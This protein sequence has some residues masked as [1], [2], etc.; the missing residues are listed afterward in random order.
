MRTFSLFTLLVLGTAPLYTFAEGTYAP[1]IQVPGFTD[2][3]TNGF[4]EYVNYL[5]ATAIAI[6][7]LL[8]VVKIIVAGVKYMTSEVVTSKGDAKKDIQGALLGLLLI[9]GAYIILNTINPQLLNQKIGFKELSKA[10]DIVNAKPPVQTP[11]QPTVPCGTESRADQLGMEITVIDLTSCTPD[12]M[13]PTE[14]AFHKKCTD[15]NRIYV[16]IATGGGQTTAKCMLATS[17]VKPAAAPPAGGGQ[18]QQGGSAAPAFDSTCIKAMNA[19]SPGYAYYN[20][21]SC[22]TEAAAKTFMQDN[23]VCGVNPVLNN[24]GGVLYCKL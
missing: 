17:S 23:G 11:S 7:A 24:G 3:L 12:Q 8:A 10:P 22:T 1:L 18:A 19:L 5:Y 16:G 15:A 21:S 14:D 9:L 6:G 13:K 4:S 20:V 2:G